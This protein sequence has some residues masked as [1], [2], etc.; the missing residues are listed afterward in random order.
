MNRED[1]MKFIDAHV[2]VWTPDTG[3]Y[4]LTQGYKKADMRPPAAV[5]LAGP[6]ARGV[7]PQG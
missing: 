1:T 3:H 6:P 7:N 5:E 2:H 4:P